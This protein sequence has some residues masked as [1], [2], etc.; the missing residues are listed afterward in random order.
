MLPR[1]ND[2]LCMYKKHNFNNM[3]NNISIKRKA[4]NVMKKN[5]AK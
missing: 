3:Q 5:K 4:R 1:H 2:Y